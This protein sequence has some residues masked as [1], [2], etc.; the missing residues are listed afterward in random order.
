AAVLTPVV[1]VVEELHWIDAASE[2]YLTFVSDVVPTARLLLVLTHRS[3]YSP[4]F[5]PRSTH[6]RLVLLPLNGH[7]MAA[8]TGS[9]LGTLQVPE[10]LRALI[11]AKA[12]GNPFFVEE[13]TK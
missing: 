9:I 4:A 12:E 8:M 3:G 11:V 7:D 2:E 13:L 6:S 5:A 10:A 1:L